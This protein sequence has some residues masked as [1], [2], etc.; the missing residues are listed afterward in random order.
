MSTEVKQEGEFK[1]KK[2]TPKKLVNQKG[3][4]TKLDLTKPGNEQGVV[5]PSVQKV[6]IP[7][8]ELKKQGKCHSRAKPR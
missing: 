3:N 6:V 7:K 8:E 5:I 1:V 4:I 2:R